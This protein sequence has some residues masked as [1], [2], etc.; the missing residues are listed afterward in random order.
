VAAA[1]SGGG[2]WQ[3]LEK[4]NA[5]GKEVVRRSVSRYVWD[6]VRALPFPAGAGSNT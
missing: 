3:A 2:A 5:Q 1:A 4:A 6:G